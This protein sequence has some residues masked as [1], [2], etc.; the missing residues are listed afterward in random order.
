M[1]TGETTMT[2]PA[3]D[4][5]RSPPTA[6]D[7]APPP[8]GVPPL[9]GMATPATES[10]DASAVDAAAAAAAAESRKPVDDSKPAQ[11]AKLTDAQPWRTSFDAFRA[12]LNPTRT[13]SGWQLNWG[14]LAALRDAHDS[15][16]PSPELL[17]A[18]GEFAWEATLSTQPDGQ[19]D[20]AKSLGL[21]LPEPYHLVCQLDGE[22]GAGQWRRFFPGD[23]VKFAGRFIGFEGEAGIRVAIRFPDD[24]PAAPEA[25]SR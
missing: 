20:W 16:A 21:A 7:S 5:Q 24:T 22:R 25:R 9:S 6:A 11:P 14:D 10:R 3:G 23:R 8:L 15:R 19:I 18:I 2:D 4:A 1:P 17:D 13:D 12:N